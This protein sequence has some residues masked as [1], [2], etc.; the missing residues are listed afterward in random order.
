MEPSRTPNPSP[1]EFEKLVLTASRRGTPG[2]VQI[3]ELLSRCWPSGGDRS[4]PA[5]IKWLREW[6]PSRAVLGPLECN[7]AAGRCAVCN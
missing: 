4:E 3:D 1:S 6:G 7:C 5:A 2:S